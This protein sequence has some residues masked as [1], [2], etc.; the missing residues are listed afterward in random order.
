MGHEAVR[1]TTEEA[2]SW[3]YYNNCIHRQKTETQKNR[4]RDR[5]ADR[6]PPRETIFHLGY[7]FVVYII[8]KNVFNKQII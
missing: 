5:F 1:T 4:D 7:Q 6:S 3:N 2:G 8:V